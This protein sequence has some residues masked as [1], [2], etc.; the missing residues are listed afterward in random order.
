[1]HHLLTSEDIR[2]FEDNGFV[3]LRSIIEPH[4]VEDLNDRVSDV[5]SKTNA[6]RRFVVPQ[7]EYGRSFRRLMNLRQYDMA[8]E[9]FV[10]AANLAEIACRLLGVSGVRISHDTAFFKPAGAPDTPVHADQYH[11]PISSDRAVTAWIPLED[12][13]LHQGP[14]AF[15][16]HAHQLSDSERELLAQ[17]NQE[18]LRTYF[19]HRGF[20]LCCHQ[21]KAGDVSFHLGWSFH[22]ALPNTGSETRKVFSIVYMDENIRLTDRTGKTPLEII[23]R[24]WCPGCEVN[25]LLSSSLNPV[26]FRLA[27]KAI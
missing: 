16:K 4:V 24:N 6:V 12:T 20:E 15:Y 1:M 27:N 8:I 17:A 14:I 18:D 21:Y 23:S 5:M 7:D 9:T 19:K 22:C 13:S 10:G 2:Y 3:V 26:V 11:W 25:G